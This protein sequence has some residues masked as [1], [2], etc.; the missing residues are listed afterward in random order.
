MKLSLSFMRLKGLEVREHYACDNNKEGTGQPPVYLK[1]LPRK[2]ESDIRL[3]SSFNF[4]LQVL[5]RI[6]KATQLPLM[7]LTKRP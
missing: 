5:E 7:M 4:E 3:Q 1:V 2:A 6:N